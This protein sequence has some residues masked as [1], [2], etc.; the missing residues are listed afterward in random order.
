MKHHSIDY[1]LSAI[2]YYKKI[3]SFRKTCDFGVF[4]ESLYNKHLKTK[5]H[6]MKIK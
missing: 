3:G 5:T 2:K 6:L 1:K 4:T